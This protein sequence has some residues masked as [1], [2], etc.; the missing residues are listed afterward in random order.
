MTYSDT[1]VIS[2]NDMLKIQYINVR[3]RTSTWISTH[4]HLADIITSHHKKWLGD[5]SFFLLLHLRL[6]DFLNPGLWAKNLVRY[7][8]A[9][10][11]EYTT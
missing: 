5:I 9:I 4:F 3:V 6:L 11:E 2:I 10:Q 1:V 7:D 8:S